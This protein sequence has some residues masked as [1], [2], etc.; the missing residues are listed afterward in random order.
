MLE[1]HFI[2]LLSLYSTVQIT[3]CFWIHYLISSSS[4]MWEPIDRAHNLSEFAK[5]TQVPGLEYESSDFSVHFTHLVILS[6][7][8]LVKEATFTLWGLGPIVVN[9][10]AG[11]HHQNNQGCRE[12]A[13]RRA[14]CG[15]DSPLWKR[16]SSNLQSQEGT[17]V[18]FTVRA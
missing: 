12:S 10:P 5:V 1:L 2:I 3:K 7:V 15:Q 18:T 14:K 17:N 11:Q 8:T 9:T 16:I 4:P 6:C 13:S